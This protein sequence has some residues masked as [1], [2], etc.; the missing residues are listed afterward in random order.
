MAGLRMRWDGHGSN[1]RAIIYADWI[2]RDSLHHFRIGWLLPIH[3]HLLIGLVASEYMSWLHSVWHDVKVLTVVF[4]LRWLIYVYKELLEFSVILQNQLPGF[5]V[6]IPLRKVVWSRRHNPSSQLSQSWLKLGPTIC[7]IFKKKE[8]CWE[9]HATSHLRWPPGC[10]LWPLTKVTFIWMAHSSSFLSA[11]CKTQTS[12]F[13]GWG[14]PFQ[15]SYQ[16][17]LISHQEFKVCEK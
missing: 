12:N 14:R 9:L 11:F 16:N 4:D 1:G 10:T 3:V 13:W 5:W 6:L 15:T 7:W 8:T 2:S 17:K